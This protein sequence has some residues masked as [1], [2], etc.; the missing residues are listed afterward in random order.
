MSENLLTL[1]GSEQFRKSLITRNLAPYNVQGV[2][3]P[4]NFP[5]NFETVLSD[6][7]VVD[8]PE[9]EESVGGGGNISQVSLATRYNTYGPG[10]ERNRVDAADQISLPSQNQGVET[11]GQVSFIA[12]NQPYQLAETQ[13]DL[14]NEFFIDAA[15]IENKYGPEGGFKNMY[16][17]TSIQSN[18][19]IYANYW[20]PPSFVPSFYSVYQILTS[21][22]PQGSVGSLS[23]DSY[24]AKIGA[25]YLKNAF[26]ERIAQQIENDTIGR[27]NLDALQDPFTAIEVL[28]GAEP[29]VERNYRITVPNGPIAR[30][31]D[32]LTQVTGTYIPASPIPG[33][34]FGFVQRSAGPLRQIIGSVSKLFNF[35]PA[36]SGS[37]LFFKN[38]GSGQITFLF[39]NIDSNLYKPNY[40]RSLLGTVIGLLNDAT[41][42][43]VSIGTFYVGSPN[44]NPSL[45]DSPLKDSP[46]NA[47]G[48]N[49]QSMVYGPDKMSKLYEGSQNNFNFGLAGK[50]TIDGGGIDGGF[51][52]TSPKYKDNAG[53]TV[54]PGG[55][56]V[57]QDPDYKS[58]SSQLT[59]NESTNYTFK[60][61]SLLDNTQRIIDS[62]PSDSN[63]YSHAGNAISNIS[64]VFND[65]YKEITKGSKVKK[66]VNQNGAEV[67]TEYCRLF[68]K[69]TPYLTYNDLQKTV[70]NTSGSELNG[71][72]RKFSY[73]VLDSTYN[74]NIAPFKNPGSTNILNNKVKKYMFSLEN[75][76]WRTSKK[77]GFT[78]NDLPVCE[79]G[80]NGGRIMW[81]PPYNLTF[82]ETVTPSFESQDFI[83]RPE[84]IY[85]YKNTKRGGSIGFKMIVDHP[86][87]LN[88]IVNKVLAKESNRQVVNEIVD[89][90]FSGCKK[91]DIYDLAAKFNTLPLSDLIAVQEIINEQNIPI[92]QIQDALNE[93]SS[94]GNNGTDNPDAASN[95]SP[96]LGDFTTYENIGFYFDNDIPGPSTVEEVSGSFEEYYNTY[97]TKLSIY[98][99]NSTAEEKPKM[100]PFFDDVIKWNFDQVKEMIK[101]LYPILSQQQATVTLIMDGSA[102]PVASAAYNKK[103]AKRRL[104][105]VKNFFKTYEL[106]LGNEVMSLKDFVD[107]TLLFTT[108]A[109]GENTNATPKASFGNVDTFSCS[110]TPGDPNYQAIGDSKNKTYSTRAMACRAVRF[111]KVIIEPTP[112]P[113]PAPPLVD[114]IQKQEQGY[115]KVINKDIFSKVKEGIS[116][117]ILRSLLSECDY[118]EVVKG[119]NPMFFDSIKDK[120]KY[121]HP[122]FHSMTPE[123]LNS[124]L[125]FLNQCARPGDTI[126]TIKPD[127]TTANGDASNTNF[128]VPPVLIL[129]I[130]D[131]FNCKII[132]GTITL[133]YENLDINPEG[134][135][136][137]PMICD[138]SLSF[139]II[140]GM[141]L[142]EPVDKLQNALSFSYY[143]NTEMYDERATPTEDTT[144]IDQAVFE[145]ILN[146]TPVVGVNS[147]GDVNQING[148]NPF[149]SIT[150][151]NLSGSSE[152]GDIN[153]QKQ[154]D[155][156]LTST[157]GYFDGILN[158]LEQ[159]IKDYGW[160]TEQMFVKTDNRRFKTGNYKNLSGTKLASKMF[161]K[162]NELDNEINDIF[163]KL[164]DSIDD[165]DNPIIKAID[166][167]LGLP[168][169]VKRDVKGNYVNYVNTLK[170]EY[171]QYLFEKEKQLTEL[172]QNYI[173]TLR[174]FDLVV[175]GNDG[176]ILTNGQAKILGLSGTT[177]IHSTSTGP[178][179]LEE[180]VTDY[181][182]VGTDMKEYIELLETH[183]L[184][185]NTYSSSKPSYTQVSTYSITDDESYQY[186]I[187]NKILSD[188]TTKNNFVNDLIKN[189]ESNSLLKITI[190]QSIENFLTIFNVVNSDSLNQVEDFKNSESYTN[191]YKDYKTIP[192]GKTRKFTYI[193]NSTT[194]TQVFQTNTK[195][196]Y[197][198]VNISND[199][200]FNDKIQLN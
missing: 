50:S 95:P 199:E 29:L 140:G 14:I 157:K 67:G 109:L 49:T 134:I 188:G 123:G 82:S 174:K 175:T 70:A 15:F 138:V 58:I 180:I 159:I 62:T 11:N 173:Q 132:P 104:S 115:Q 111:N 71:N 135:G 12:N 183:Y 170:S 75:L 45:I 64:K 189:N 84:P 106:D 55:K 193:S 5:Q 40:D 13:L 44:S 20:G 151:F 63:R 194:S 120:I 57:A 41:D 185:T 59:S 22:N 69:D 155:D 117:K 145:A 68:T 32:I 73:S 187:M 77:P 93:I 96:E 1:Q 23:Q 92:E 130:G 114:P 143:A 79:R 110:D 102:S 139:D 142:K 141:G 48:Q 90:F 30:S 3:T 19:N 167:T 124:R 153:Y 163:N 54:G 160:A 107:K 39:R 83:G 166:N 17:V 179:T 190:E 86:S 94:P 51:T 125:V 105:S 192:S 196:I 16:F 108:T 88:L 146:Q 89:S 60:T 66:Y 150:K 61:N 47:F 198:K 169:S 76:A 35:T 98:Q 131:F 156:L 136:V 118:F 128:G 80:P 24:L 197:S 144:A 28:R 152:T 181:T 99:S 53:F 10:G 116:K 25:Q 178:T 18:D 165:D 100:Q 21:D 7:S 8:A 158:S 26:Q 27:V 200:T 122:G 112:P 31:I 172:Q 149:G 191:K 127:G 2:Y 121:F 161:G 129:R 81:F 52:W 74:L 148:G 87:V 97:I 182:Q 72:I 162:N 113:A 38:T 65:G 168:N 184:I 126:P 103:I 37:E 34:Y 85:T 177:D 78:Y 195:N 164:T 46:D 137:Q 91:Y 119:S 133:K 4:P 33:D 176:K 171:S 154:F 9:I 6:S 186:Q 56:N 147:V 42:R 101:Q 43:N 36:D